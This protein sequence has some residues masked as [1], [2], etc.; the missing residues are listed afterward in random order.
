[1]RRIFLMM[2]AVLTL[3][4]AAK[5]KVKKV[6]ETWPDGTP[7]DAWFQDTTKVDVSKLGRQYVLTD[8]DVMM[9]SS[10]FR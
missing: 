1:M 8:Y 9:G 4:A 7:M 3:S 6:V 5:P 2:L 10:E